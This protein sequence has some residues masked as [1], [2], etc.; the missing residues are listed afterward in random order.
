[1]NTW[2]PSGRTSTTRNCGILLF[3]ILYQTPCVGNDREHL[4]RV[5]VYANAVGANG[6][7]GLDG[8]SSH[9][10][11]Y[12]YSENGWATSITLQVREGGIALTTVANFVDITPM[13]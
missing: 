8:R 7:T 13:I 4:S 9:Y 1:M 11:V 2:L 3:L 10:P 6:N 5:R 12:A